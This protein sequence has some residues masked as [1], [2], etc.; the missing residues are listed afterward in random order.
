MTSLLVGNTTWL[1]SRPTETIL[2]RAKRPVLPVFGR[3]LGLVAASVALGFTAF[4]SAPRADQPRPA[5]A[6]ALPS[7]AATARPTVQPVSRADIAISPFQATPMGASTGFSARDGVPAAES[8]VA[9]APAAQSRE[10]EFANVEVVDGRTLLAG[11]VRIHLVGLD[12]PMPEQ[13]CRTLDGRLEACAVRA[14]TQ[15]ELLTRWKRVACHYRLETAG[16][17]TG[18]CRIGTSDL[19]DRMIKTGY[20]WRSV[21]APD[22]G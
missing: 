11:G 20:A 14:A 5:D 16:E 3:T 21:G 13:V 6:T 8:F 17:G 12:L 2:H 1:L 15:L 4:T 7:L 9:P 19:T 22:K 10:E 18:R